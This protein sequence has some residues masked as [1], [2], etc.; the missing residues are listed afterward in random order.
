MPISDSFWGPTEMHTNRAFFMT[1]AWCLLSPP[2][3]SE[4]HESEMIIRVGLYLQHPF[5]RKF[6]I[7]QSSFGLT[8]N[9]NPPI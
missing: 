9:V 7:L 4:E 8:L 1:V 5:R 6:Q 2:S 3:I